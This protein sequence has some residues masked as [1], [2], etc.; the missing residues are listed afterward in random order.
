MA[1]AIAGFRQIGDRHVVYVYATMAAEVADNRNYSL[2]VVI[3][4]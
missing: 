2:W 3:C 4:V 1:R